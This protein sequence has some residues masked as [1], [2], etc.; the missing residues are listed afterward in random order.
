MREKR[1]VATV[2]DNLS[3]HGGRRKYYWTR[4]HRPCHRKVSV[5]L[6]LGM[7]HAG[8]HHGGRIHLELY[9]YTH[10]TSH[11]LQDVKNG[12]CTLRILTHLNAFKDMKLVLEF[13]DKTFIY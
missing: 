3:A 11:L 2:F 7:R 1:K 6:E 5:T 9:A 13:K 10:D 4:L 12:T 8:I